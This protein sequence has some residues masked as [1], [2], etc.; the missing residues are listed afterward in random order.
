MVAAVGNNRKW[1]QN[2]E[3]KRYMSQSTQGPLAPKSINVTNH[4][5]DPELSDSR[6]RSRVPSSTKRVDT[7][8]V[9]IELVEKELF[10]LIVRSSRV[11][12]N[13]IVAESVT[14]VGSQS[15][16][17]HLNAVVVLLR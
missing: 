16:L 5:L 10:Q 17:V 8:C 15:S 7:A 14:S 3:L 11:H 6:G 1:R 9:S 4:R 13:F 2:N 12:A